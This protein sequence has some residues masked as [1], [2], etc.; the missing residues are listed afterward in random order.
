MAKFLWSRLTAPQIRLVLFLFG[1]SP[2][3]LV[4]F[5]V[6]IGF[7]QEGKLGLAGMATA[8]YWVK[9]MWP[10]LAP[11]ANLNY[12]TCHCW[13]LHSRPSHTPHLPPFSLSPVVALAQ[14][15]PCSIGRACADHHAPSAAARGLGPSP[16]SSGGGMRLAIA[17][18]DTDQGRHLG[19]WL[20]SRT[21]PRRVR[22]RQ[23]AV[24]AHGLGEQRWQRVDGLEGP[25]GWAQQAALIGSLIN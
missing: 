21:G 12:K 17:T 18:A 19:L 14:S 15:P 3:V 13:P 16:S 7:A 2:G 22:I 20:R 11:L 5:R 24:I 4:S 1:C 8:V 9:S 10:N 23:G 25:R 6:R